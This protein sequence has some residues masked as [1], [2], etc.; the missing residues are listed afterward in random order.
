[1]YMSWYE[2]HAMHDTGHQE[3]YYK[4]VRVRYSDGDDGATGC[5]SLP[6]KV[7]AD[8]I[9]WNL[10]SM[11]RNVMSSAMYQLNLDLATSAEKSDR[12]TIIKVV[13]QITSLK[14]VCATCHKSS[15]ILR[16]V[17]D[18]VNALI[19]VL[20]LNASRLLL[21]ELSDNDT[22]VFDWR[23]HYVDLGIPIATTNQANIEDSAKDVSS[24]RMDNTAD[25]AH[26]AEKSNGPIQATQMSLPKGKK[27]PTPVPHR[28]QKVTPVL[29]DAMNVEHVKEEEPSGANDDIEMEQPTG[30]NDAIAESNPR[31]SSC[32]T[33]DQV[34]TND[35]K[36]RDVQKGDANDCVVV[37]ESGT[38]HLESDPDA[39][40]LLYK[41]INQLALEPGSPLSNPASLG[42]GDD[43]S[44]DEAMLAK[45]VNLVAELDA[46]D[47]SASAAPSIAPSEGSLASKRSRQDA[48]LMSPNNNKKHKHATNQAQSSHA[49]DGDVGII[50]APGM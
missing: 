14:L 29:Q 42:D 15:E 4:R 46:S 20:I 24:N 41:S 7:L 17:A 23:E 18:T 1:M 2:S 9:V 33:F 47:Q 21:H 8:P 12:D 50:A 5:Q 38:A 49:D 48:M 43:Q 35:P 37:R 39:A 45:D 40:T 22:A 44:A 13:K 10:H 3:E 34:L 26:A 11:L 19:E 36:V 27:K 28:A 32:I 16:D 6:A 30:L 31:S 25:D